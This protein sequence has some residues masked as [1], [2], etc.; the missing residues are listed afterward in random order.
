MARQSIGSKFNQPTKKE[1][2]NALLKKDSETKPEGKFSEVPK[3]DNE[4]VGEDVP[5]KYRKF[6]KN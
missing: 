3:K 1:D 5:G 6:Q 2:Q 4:R